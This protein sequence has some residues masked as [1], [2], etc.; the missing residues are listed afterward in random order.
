MTEP[1]MPQQTDF[2][3]P[4]DLPKPEDDGAAA[5]LLGLRMPKILL[6]STKDRI[7]DLSDLQALRTVIYCYPM[8]GVPGKPLPEGWDLIP[9]ARG[10]TPQTCAFRDLHAEL[11]AAG[12]AH[13]FGLSTQSNAYQAEMAVRL[14]LP[15]PVLSDEKLELTRALDLPTMEVAGLTLMKRLALIVDGGRISHVFYP[16]FPPD[17]NAGDVLAWLNANRTIARPA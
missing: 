17:R 13:V 12:A 3:L 7:V 10:C 8:T 5:H 1:Q 14:H 15:F 11:K 9:G 6:C 16:V 2:P 4:T